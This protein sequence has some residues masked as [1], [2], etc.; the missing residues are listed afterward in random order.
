V[1]DN[2]AVLT[3]CQA[4]VTRDGLSR[5]DLKNISLYAQDTVVRGRLTA[6]L[7]I[8][9]DYNHDQ[10][11]DASVVAN[12]LVPTILP[13]LNFGG[14][15][16]NIAFNDLSPRLGLTYDL[17]GTGKTIAKANYAMYWGQV[18]TGGVA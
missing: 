13:A 8:R 5:Y 17:R 18:G 14:L 10:V 4:Q 11:L 2:C 7:G 9:Y 16:P 1:T 6:Q 3:T 12:P 15:D